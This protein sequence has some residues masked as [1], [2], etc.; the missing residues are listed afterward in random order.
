LFRFRR[1]DQHITL[2]AEA[3]EALATLPRLISL[4][5]ETTSAELLRSLPQLSRLK[6]LCLEMGW[7]PLQ[8]EAAAADQM[9]NALQQQCG[10]LTQLELTSTPFDS[11]HLCALLPA[12]PLLTRFYILGAKNL[13]SLE[14]FDS[15]LLASSLTDLSL[16]DCPACPLS[17]LTHLHG[18]RSL[19]RLRVNLQQYHSS[20]QRAQL[21]D[22]SY[23]F[24]VPRYQI[25][26]CV[27]AHSER[28][29][30]EMEWKARHPEFTEPQESLSE[31]LRGPFTPPV[32][33]ALFPALR[34]FDCT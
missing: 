34:S 16:L 21:R 6:A 29:I 13:K 28:G 20:V 24:R 33:L 5:V 23:D 26:T 3:I 18:L 15:P 30:A 2:N 22:G 12:L 10:Q 25:V 27:Y 11:A 32:S 31:E 17:E 7:L 9:A 1:S 19:Q 14:Y 8:Q 4:S